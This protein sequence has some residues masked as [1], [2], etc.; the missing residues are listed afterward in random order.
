M[1][2][3]P[4]KQGVLVDGSTIATLVDEEFPPIVH[5]FG[6]GSGVFTQQ[7]AGT[8]ASSLNDAGNNMMIDLI[9]V[10][11]D[12]LSFHRQN[13]KRN[14]HHYAAWNRSASF[15]SWLQTNFPAKVFFHPN[16]DVRGTN[17]K[18]GVVTKRHLL[19]DLREWNYLYL[20]G[21]LHKPTLPIGLQDQDILASQATENLPGALAVSL[22]LLSQEATTTP[23]EVDMLSVYEQIAR[24]SYDGDPRVGL[25]GEDPQKVHKLVHAPGQAERFFQLYKDSLQDLSSSGV[26]S[27]D[28][29]KIQWNPEESVAAL[30]ANL[31][32]RLQTQP[33][34]H[35]ELRETVRRAARPQMLKGLV[36]AG[37]SRSARYVLSKLSK[38]ILAR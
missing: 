16:V 6:Y 13:L 28:E 19:A 8:T 33:N 17:I 35:V 26:I 5:C 25:G 20:A 14:S 15:C 36:T 30:R 3:T 27:Y 18:Y 38:G 32:R 29:L 12:A 2:S 22:L 24:L 9:L 1:T 7:Q 21:R 31:P 11:E 4:P 23:Q 37:V 34:L 10:V